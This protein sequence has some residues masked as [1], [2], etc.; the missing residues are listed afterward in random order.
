MQGIKKLKLEKMSTRVLHALVAL[1]VL[2]FGAFFFIGYDTPFEEN[3]E[4]NAPL[5]TDLVLVFI[6]AMVTAAIVLTGAAVTISMKTGGKANKETNNIPAAKIAWGTI[7][8]LVICLAAT[9]A[10]GSSEPVTVNG[11]KFDD[12]FWLKATDMFIN[13]SF[14]LLAIAVCG[15]A[16]GLSGYNRKIS[17]KKH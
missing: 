9:F 1:T 17:I 12:T 13:T 14:I 6:Y 11:T 8:L 16:L 2:V 3:P 10:T 4:Y 15:V 5:L 7:L